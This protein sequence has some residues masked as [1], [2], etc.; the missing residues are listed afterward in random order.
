MS[1]LVSII[2]PAHNA[3]KTINSSIN[4]V[5]N[6]TY[7][8]WELIVINDHSEDL[9]LDIVNNFIKDE[10]RIVL[11]NN[12]SDNRGA[13]Y[14]RNLG[15]SKAKGR[16]IAFLDSDDSWLPHKLNMQI[17]AMKLSG[18]SVSHTGYTRISELG[19]FISDVKVKNI[20]TYAD[21]LKTNQI[22][23]LTG[24]YDGKKLGI[25]K[26]K[27]IGHEDYEMWLNILEKSPSLGINIP[28]AKYRVSSNS[29]SSNKLKAAY[30]HYCIISNRK[31]IGLIRRFY[32]F[33][34]YVSMAVLKRI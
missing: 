6:Q 2:M 26:Q 3:E 10:Q 34:S 20:V 14:S 25:V 30:W 1:N 24:I 21:Q 13:Y 22:P 18:H 12:T 32:L 23:N 4:S 5:I 31:N 33:L 19:E 9:T 11:L 29:L 27:C 17:E 8:E 28:L 7:N 16:Y 15:L